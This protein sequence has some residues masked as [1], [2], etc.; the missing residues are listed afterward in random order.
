MPPSATRFV[1]SM[2]GSRILMIS[3]SLRARST[4]SALL[5][6]VEQ[7]RLPD[8]VAT[9]YRGSRACRTSIPTTTMNHSIRRSPSCVDRFMA[10]TRCSFPRLNMRARSLVR[11]RMRWTG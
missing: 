10:P 5:D 11:S 6:T 2:E 7:L 8:I 3:G 9:R 4:N 1:P